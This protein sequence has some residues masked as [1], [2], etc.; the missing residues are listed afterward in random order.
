MGYVKSYLASHVCQSDSYNWQK[1]YQYNTPYEAAVDSYCSTDRIQV[2]KTFVTQSTFA[3]YL[4]R[5]VYVTNFVDGS[6]SQCD[7]TSPPVSVESL[8]VGSCVWLNGTGTQSLYGILSY[9]YLDSASF[10]MNV[11]IYRDNLCTIKV[12]EF[13]EKL[14]IDGCKPIVGN[15]QFSESFMF[16]LVPA[17]APDHGLGYSITKYAV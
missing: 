8:A 1:D 7:S 16:S 3:G 5:S 2:N 12:S 10:L 6:Y 9:G 15:L 14:D 17:I 13:S 11:E 4:I